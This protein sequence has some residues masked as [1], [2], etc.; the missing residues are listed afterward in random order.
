MVTGW[1]NVSSAM[2]LPPQN[3]RE[4]AWAVTQSFPLEPLLSYYKSKTLKTH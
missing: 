1:N 4:D 2:Y 3:H